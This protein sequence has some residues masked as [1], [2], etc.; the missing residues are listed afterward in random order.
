MTNFDTTKTE[1]ENLYNKLAE[2][3]EVVVK[4]YPKQLEE[5]MGCPYSVVYYAIDL[6]KEFEDKIMKR[7]DAII[8]LVSDLN[9]T[10]NK[11]STE[12]G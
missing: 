4:H 2:L 5:M 6:L 9:E 10:Q 11:K 3:R 12:R 8:K 7:D 1:E